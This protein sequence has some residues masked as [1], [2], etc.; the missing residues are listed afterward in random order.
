MER[1]TNKYELQV[2]AEIRQVVGGMGGLQVRENVVIT[3][4]SFLEICSI[5]G[6]FHKLAETMRIR[7]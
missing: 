2:T 5:L 1:D 3:A 7:R 4:D 6:E